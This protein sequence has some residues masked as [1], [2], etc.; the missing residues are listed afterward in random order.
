MAK[1]RNR[2]APAH[3]F[4]PWHVGPPLNLPPFATIT[5]PRDQLPSCEPLA[6]SIHFQHVAQ[7]QLKQED[8]LVCKAHT[9]SAGRRRDSH[10][11]VERRLGHRQAPRWKA[12]RTASPP[13]AP[14][15]RDPRLRP[16][17]LF[18]RLSQVGRSTILAQR[19]GAGS[20]AIVSLPVPA[21][22]TR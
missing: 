10:R 15:R 13:A 3:S 7:L 17:A 11:C 21:K 19:R 2:N 6:A 14:R 4:D 22:P 1:R 9:R 8:E 20:Q 12:R 5:T 18:F 16:G